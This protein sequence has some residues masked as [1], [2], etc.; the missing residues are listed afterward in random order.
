[1]ATRDINISNAINNISNNEFVP[2]I[3][4]HDGWNR[5]DS[6]FFQT[7]FASLRG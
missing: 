5:N 7:S 6:K 4:F 1:M 2:G 3:T